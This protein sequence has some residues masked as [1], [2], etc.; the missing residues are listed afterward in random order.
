MKAPADK[1]ELQRLVEERLPEA[2][3]FATRLTGDPVEA[4]DLLQDALVRAWQGWRTFR[5]GSSA[6][7]W[8][9]R[10]MINVFRDRTRWA[11]PHAPLREPPPDTRSHDPADSA[12]C[13]ELQGLVARHV[14]ALPPRQRE[15]LVMLAY[16]GFTVEETAHTLGISPANVHATLH[17]A[18]VRLREAL[19]AYLTP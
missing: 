1:R 14:S 6:R 8:L 11:R 19:A 18:R 3:R 2:L 9:Y 5:G 13:A 17:H 15:V 12:A 16:E 7:T 4:E 10:I